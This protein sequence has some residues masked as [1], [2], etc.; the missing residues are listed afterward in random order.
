[1]LIE[2]V[3]SSIFAVCTGRPP[4]L[5][6]TNSSSS[7]AVFA[8]HIFFGLAGVE[9][10]RRR[11]APDG[12][13][14]VLGHMPAGPAGPGGWPA[15]IVNHHGVHLRF[16]H[17]YLH[18][19]DDAVRSTEPDRSGGTTG[20]CTGTA[21][22]VVLAEGG[23]YPFEPAAASVPVVRASLVL[24]LHPADTRRIPRRVGAGE[25]AGVCR[26]CP[27]HREISVTIRGF[28]PRRVRRLVAYSVRAR[29][30]WSTTAR[31]ISGLRD[32]FV[33]TIASDVDLLRRA[34]DRTPSEREPYPDR[35]IHSQNTGGPLE[36]QTCELSAAAGSAFVGCA[37]KVTDFLVQPIGRSVPD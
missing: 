24:H 34:C 23:S 11:D 8:C 6:A 1:M 22:R 20:A 35:L 16:P 28:A 10:R 31:R 37:N 3:K 13:G 7:L 25:V 27:A 33:V 2:I 36:L 32:E 9:G 4:S 21:V 15:E 14:S 18:P 29:I 17:V 12:T 5:L 26:C 19:V 30:D